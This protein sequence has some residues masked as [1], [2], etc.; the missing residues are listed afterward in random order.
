MEEEGKR[1]GRGGGEEGR[2][3]GEEGKR[4][5]RGRKRKKKKKK[6][7]KKKKKKKKKKEEEKEKKRVLENLHAHSLI[8]A[9]LIVCVT[10]LRSPCLSLA[11]GEGVAVVSDPFVAVLLSTTRIRWKP[12]FPLDQRWTEC[13]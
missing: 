8:A 13:E 3:G 2:G 9:L 6:E 5:G 7:R 4:R 12:A 11:D 1:R 10:R